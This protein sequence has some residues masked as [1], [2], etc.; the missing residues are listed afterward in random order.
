MIVDDLNVIR[1]AVLPAEADTPLVIDADAM[2]SDS[3]T[4]KLLETVTRGNTK[5]LEG[6]GSVDG[7]EL[8]QHRPL[9]VRRIAADPLTAEEC[10]GVA[11]AKALDHPRS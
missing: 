5:I 3:V 6:F 4:P 11:I 9:E 8:P 1:V 10:L 2:L 7:D